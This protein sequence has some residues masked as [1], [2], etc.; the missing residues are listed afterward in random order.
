MYIYIHKYV[1]KHNIH[2]ISLTNISQAEPIPVISVPVVVP[3]DLHLER[4]V[5]AAAAA[6]LR[7]RSHG[8]S[9]AAGIARGA[10]GIWRNKY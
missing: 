6:A 5:E 4:F 1:Y 3:G 7:S 8:G 2:I 10:A 9:A